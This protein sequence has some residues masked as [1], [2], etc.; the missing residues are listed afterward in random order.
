M[1]WFDDL[2]LRAKLM[3]NFAL[4]GGLLV[5]VILVC[6]VQINRMENAT[7]ELVNWAVPMMVNAAALEEFRMRYRIRS[8]EFMLA[9]NGADRQK[10]Q[11]SLQ[12]IDATL[13]KKVEETRTLTTWEESKALLAE[14]ERA[15]AAY[16]DSVMQAV[17]L[18]NSG[19]RGEAVQLQNTEWLRLA[20]D[21]TK[22]TKSLMVYATGSVERMGADSEAAAVQAEQIAIIGLVLGVV[23]AALI[24]LLVARRISARLE[25]A[26]AQ[27]DSIA[28]GTL[29][30]DEQHVPRAGADEVGHLLQAMG[31]MRAALRDTIGG[32]RHEATDLS[33][34][35]E[36]LGQVVSE[37]EVSVDA[38]SREASNIAASVEQ[39][40]VSI[41]EVATRTNEASLAAQESDA[42]AREG[43]QVLDRL[44]Q[45]IVQVESV[46]NTAAEGIGSLA[47]ESKK[48][49]A[50]VGVI[51]EIADQTNLL[52]LN[53]AIEAARAGEQGRGFA[54]V[55]DEVRAL[56]QRTHASTEE[57]EALIAS[58]QEMSGKAATRMESSQRLTQ[59]SVTLASD[60]GGALQ[61]I[62]Q[63]VANIEQMNQQIAA[64]AEEQSVTAET[65]SQ[66]MV[67]VRDIGVQTA[68]AGEQTAASSNELA[69][70]GVELRELV[71]QF[72][73]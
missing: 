65:I 28:A 31:R 68:A 22:A 64:A 25:V 53:A 41:G 1:N 58:L 70:L 16:R 8:L 50:I 38:Q 54:V 29:S 24:A 36:N 12:E 23:L 61:R 46:I 39:V 57:I 9:D 27:A 7:D 33:G 14:F 21:V 34:A 48:I 63:A 42:K 49:S 40:T 55:A 15:A 56:A 43:S 37:L 13:R 20:G 17:A 3:V 26:V 11:T 6:Y 10:T 30:F 44:E 4:S 62:A 2:S 45:D 19:R 51:R 59:D 18:V 73:R 69:R 72:R 71:G 35:A 52:A 5:A 60:A 47:E 32:V 67:R 66:N